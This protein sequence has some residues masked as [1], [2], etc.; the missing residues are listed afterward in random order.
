LNSDC[1]YTGHHS[2]DI[3][4]KETIKRM[5]Q[6]LQIKGYKQKKVKEE[7]RRIIRMNKTEKTGMRNES[8]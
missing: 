5:L 2:R 1:H 8:Y 6:K 7:V 4:K 3:N